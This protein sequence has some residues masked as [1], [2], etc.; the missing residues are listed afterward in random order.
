MKTVKSIA[1][2][3]QL[4]LARGAKVELGA[5]RF[6]TTNER[7]T[8]FP[9]REAASVESVPVPPPQ[10]ARPP[11]EMPPPP[12]VRVDLAAVAEAQLRVGEMLAQAVSSLPA[13][14]APA[15]WRFRV[16]R[17]AKGLIES[18]DAFPIKE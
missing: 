8:A 6:N 14:A 1:D 11:P 13:S 17:D 9:K 10:V 7:V 5:T 2:L 3:K 15:S 18:I 16:N 4:A 12:E